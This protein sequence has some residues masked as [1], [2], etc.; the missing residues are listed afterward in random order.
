[1]IPNLLRASTSE[2]HQD[3]LNWIPFRH[4][5]ALMVGYWRT[6]S[7]RFS[8]CFIV[9]L[10]RWILFLCLIFS[11]FKCFL[12]V[13][14]LQG[15]STKDFNIS[16]VD[17]DLFFTSR[18]ILFLNCGDNFP[19]CLSVFLFH[20]YLNFSSNCRESSYCVLSPLK[21]LSVIF[22]LFSGL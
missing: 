13:L 18:T 3:C 4:S 15:A 2:S 8:L 9:N 20:T 12:F 7:S 10:G 11:L 6:Y 22:R 17:E 1:M 19:A 14:V 5:L 21:F 16:D